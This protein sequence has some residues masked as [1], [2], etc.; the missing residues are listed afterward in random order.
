MRPVFAQ[1]PEVPA[2]TGRVVLAIHPTASNA[3]NTSLRT[4]SNL[5][6]FLEIIATS[7]RRLEGYQNPCRH[8]GS[9][10]VTDGPTNVH[11]IVPELPIRIPVDQVRDRYL[12][13]N[14]HKRVNLLQIIV[15]VG[16]FSASDGLALRHPH[17][18]C[19]S[20]SAPV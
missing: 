10:G 2:K 1:V 6:S 12:S 5:C 14:C 9:G 11:G 3:A 19:V 15:R 7:Y 20:V 17:W 4:A 8:G 13:S 16:E 18:K